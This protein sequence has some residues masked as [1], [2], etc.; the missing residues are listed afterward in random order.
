MKTPTNTRRRHGRPRRSDVVP[1][2]LLF[3]LIPLTAI[4]LLLGCVGD[5]GHEIKY[6]N[7]LNQTVSVYIDGVRDF[8][9]AP[10]ES[11]HYTLLTL[12]HAALFEAKSEDN[13]VLFSKTLT[14]DDLR[15]MGWAI[16]IE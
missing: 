11:N 4:V 2:C 5:S 9:L 7:H 12:K 3:C 13:T 10:N 14:W 6:S 16:V 15:R 1:A 8:A